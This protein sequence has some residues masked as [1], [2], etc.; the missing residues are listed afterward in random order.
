M[1]S[2]P[3]AISPELWCDRRRAITA[4]LRI[5]PPCPAGIAGGEVVSLTLDDIDWETGAEHSRKSGQ[6]RC[7]PYSRL[8]VKRRRL[9][10]AVVPIRSRSVFCA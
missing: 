1:V 5:L 3:K 9:P 4:G 8:W 7:C 2:I 10:K 6:S